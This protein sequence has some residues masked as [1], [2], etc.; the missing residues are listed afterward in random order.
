MNRKNTWGIIFAGVIV[1]VSVILISRYITRRT[2]L[3]V[4]GTVECTT[5]R[6]S[7]KI[8][9]RIAT[10]LVAQGDRVEQ[11]QLLYTLTTPELNA[12]LQQAEAAKSAARLSML[13]HWPVLVLNRFKRPKISGKKHRPEPSWLKRPTSV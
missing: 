11:G 10:M 1:V 2:P 3:I 13:R 12:K 8:P 7:S 4:Q 9:G 6:A 5:Y